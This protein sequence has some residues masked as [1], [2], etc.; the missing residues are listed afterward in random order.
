[1]GI[2]SSHA[3]P[4][5]V[6]YLGWP[7]T[8]GA[9]FYDYLLADPIVVPKENFEHFSENIVWLP[10]CYQSNDRA[11]KISLETPS[12][13][14]CDLPETGF[15]FC[16]FNSTFKI[17][18]EIFDVWMR[19]I[20]ATPSSVLWLLE[21]SQTACENLRRE[22]SIRG[23]NPARLIFAPRVPNDQH[24]ARLT[25]ADLVLDTIPY[26]AHTTASDALWMGVPVVTCTGWTFASRVATSL[27]HNVGLPELA[28]TNLADYE[29][30]ALRLAVELSLIKALKEKLLAQRLS[31]PLFD[32]P[33]LTRDI[34]TAYREM[35]LRFDGNLSPDFIDVRALSE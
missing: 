34:E 12:R 18:P 10:N 15:V 1:M 8:A 27:L 17:L 25:N 30:L 21:T 6:L 4:V 26:N 3:V 11:R 22:A 23:V 19:L 28:V 33:Q 24:L 9:H 31:A 2:F 16:C 7:G 5:Q 29:S 13:K 20:Q 14:A 32:T 35:M